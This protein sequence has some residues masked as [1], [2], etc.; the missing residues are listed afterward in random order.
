MVQLDT[1]PLQLIAAPL[2]FVLAGLLAAPLVDLRRIPLRIAIV[3]CV[4]AVV[5]S[6]L[7]WRLS[8]TMPWAGSWY[9]LGF[10]LLCLAIELFGLFDAGILYAGL[11]RVTNRSAEAD[12]GEARLALLP[13]ETW[14][15]V[16]LIICSYN[17][18]LEVL[19]KTIIGAL[20]LDWP[21]L[22]V[23][24]ADDGRRVWL[25]D[26]CAAKGAGYIT[27]PD[28]AHAKAGNINHAL[29]VTNAPFIAVFDAD[30]VPQ[31]QFL[32]RTMGFFDDP[33]IGIV[34]IPHSFYNHDPLQQNL[35]L[36]D[37]V[38][39]DQRFFFEAIMPGR[40]GWDAAFCYGSN[41]VTRRTAFEKIGGGLPTGSITED[42]LLTLALLRHGLI[43]R[44]LN[45]PL[46]FGLAPE[47]LAAFFVQRARW[48]R[49]AMQILFLKE[50]PLGPG[51]PL[52]PAFL[53]TDSMAQ[54]VSDAADVL[55]RAINIP[56]LR[57]SAA[58]RSDARKRDLLPGADGR[59]A[60]RRYRP[61]WV[62][63]GIIRLR[64]KFSV[65]FRASVFYRSL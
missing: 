54:P 48:A 24:V 27:R 41:S 55:G 29:S 56:V 44:Y 30:F 4:S 1:A 32:T 57:Y 11:A 5:A 53:S 9:G 18:P 19:E 33:K 10:A 20:A 65:H 17:E 25:R 43:T 36:R 39:D 62:V 49:G 15:A 64:P 12:D 2:L 50:G 14:P 61:S 46:A 59:G 47:S 37:A 60:G 6:Y 16:D 34:Q 35:A 58:G 26:F 52:R 3:V 7:S 45:E 42:M 8:V 28:N 38:P 31:R 21:T 63:G 51:L 13:R 22:N 23:W 40:D